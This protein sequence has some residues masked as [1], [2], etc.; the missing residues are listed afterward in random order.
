M[1]APDHA[2]AAA[3]DL[4]ARGLQRQLYA[5]KWPSLRPIQVDAIRRFATTDDDLLIMAETAGGKTEAAFL[6]VLS[7]IST[8]P[9]GS[10]RALY[11]G[12]LKA[13]I[14]DQFMR[15]DDLC[16]H[17]DMPVHRWHGDVSKASKDALTKQPS[18]VLLI[19]PESLESLLV[20]RTSRL[21]AM[22]GGLRAVVIDEVHAFLEG[23]R[24]LHLA[25]LL[26][27]LL[28][29]V[30]P[31]GPRTRFV[32]LSATVGDTDTARRFLSPDAPER[33]FLITNQRE[34]PEVLIRIHGY[35]Y[36]G[37]PNTEEPARDEDHRRTALM[38]LI[39]QDLVEHCRSHAN[40]VFANAK[41]DIEIYADMANEA[42]RKD[43]IPET[44]LVHHGSLAREEREDTEAMMK[45]GKAHTTICSSTLEM[46][47]DIG[48]VR[49]VG[50]IGAPWAVSSFKQRLGRSGRRPGESRRCRGY[51]VC[52]LADPGSN[53]IEALPIEL[54]Q[55][56]AITELM[57]RKWVEPPQPAKL[58]LSTLTHQV[59]ST[60]CE[61]HAASAADLFDRLCVRGP[62]RAVDRGLFARVLRDLGK[63]Q[64][65][66]QGRD[67][68][69]IL[70][71]VGERVRSQKDFYAAF[72]SRAEY[73][74]VAP[75]RVLGTLPMDT[76]PAPGEHIVFAARRWRVEE[77]DPAKMTV[78]VRPARERK[79]PK[80]L[81]GVGT[82]HPMIGEEM[83]RLLATTHEP[84]YLDQVC[85]DALR[86]ARELAARLGLAT[87]G[88]IPHAKHGSLWLTWT[89]SKQQATLV[90]VLRTNRI[91][92]T[93]HRVGLRCEA[94]ASEVN[95]LLARLR[96]KPLNVAA[97]A[98]D[99]EPKVLRKYDSF[100]SAES[101]AES[102]AVDQLD[103]EALS[104][105]EQP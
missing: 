19:T 22:F 63:S 40:L 5:L 35:R 51:V 66:E 14:N 78:H 34:A 11:I 81:G 9:E 87:R 13:L 42:C 56:V 33:V 60:I 17:L 38:E 31:D 45:A 85:R 58:D 91:E 52:D 97:L 21:H 103:P 4:L 68:L 15:L 10:V 36:E 98:R 50:Q 104:M 99:F 24:G 37:E 47:V 88:V 8:E 94:D 73:T 101:L 61:L 12:P 65:I 72:A 16:Q 100:L 55:T 93:D 54:L 18:G 70:G 102:I 28:R 39:A 57:L 62:F 90:A 69:L 95:A 6:P 44:F 3:F 75:D 25:S 83:R 29:Y 53:P 77:V 82:I 26:S 79:R 84:V 105:V 27:R 30:S 74:L 1:S 43:G 32:G 20:N 48:S 76:V 46:G 49:T 23:E 71:L 80:F 59:I 86:S 41:G 64:I 96:G 67:G 7:A 89:G 92:P 2:N